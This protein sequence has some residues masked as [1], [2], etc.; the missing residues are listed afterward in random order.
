M[1]PGKIFNS[2]KPHKRSLFISHKSPATMSLLQHSGRMGGG[3][4]GGT[5]GM[6]WWECA[7]GT[8]EPLAY[9]KASSAE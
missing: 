3:G 1:M 6:F 7:A 5:L 2:Q 4:G 8:L 9:T